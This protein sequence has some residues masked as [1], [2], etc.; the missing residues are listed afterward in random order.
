MKTTNYMRSPIFLVPKFEPT[1]DMY[2][3]SDT[4]AIPMGGSRVRVHAIS[5]R[6]SSLTAFARTVSDSNFIAAESGPEIDMLVE[7]DVESTSFR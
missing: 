5:I 6:I 4:E 7:F 2:S 3:C 1:A